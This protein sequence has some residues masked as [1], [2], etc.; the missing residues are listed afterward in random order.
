MDPNPGVAVTGL[1][2]GTPNEL[3]VTVTRAVPMT[4]MKMVGLNSFNI[5][6]V[7]TAAIVDVTSA[8]THRDHAP[9]TK[10]G[11][12][13]MNGTTGITVCGGPQ[14]SVQVNS[15]SASA[16]TGAAM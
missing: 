10:S 15:T 1:D 2:A 9:D 8:P 5:T 11:A 3:Q 13:D 16:L 14:R 12:L 4:L 6:A 7:A